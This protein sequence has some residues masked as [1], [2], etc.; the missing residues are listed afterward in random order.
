[1]SLA[2]VKGTEAPVGAA[3]IAERYAEIVELWDALLRQVS[4]GMAALLQTLSDE[5]VEDLFRRLAEENEELE[6]DYSGIS[7]EERRAKQGKAIS[8]AFRR[9]TGP[10]NPAQEALIVSGTE[11]SHDVS[12]DWLRRRTAW[13]REFRLLMEGRK[14]A[15]GFAD[16]FTD[17]VLNPNQFD[18]P[19]YRE[20]VKDNQQQSF[21]LVAEVLGTLSPRQTK[22]LRKT[23]KTYANDFEGLIRSGQSPPTGQ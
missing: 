6:E 15:S 1:M 18:S 16:R 9:F 17:L 4:P 10:L 11:N 22:H 20:L 2:V 19:G 21:E 14:S 12:G 3:F 7:L 13:Q 23:F 5:Q 8:R